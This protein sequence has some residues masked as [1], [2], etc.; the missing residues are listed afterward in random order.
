MG[1]EEEG[2]RVVLVELVRSVPQTTHLVA[3]SLNRVPQV[4]QIFVDD[5]S[6]LI[7][8]VLSPGER[9]IPV[10]ENGQFHDDR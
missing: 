4:G 5:L 3:F 1:F 7:V 10:F 9:I 2:V 8:S 6:G